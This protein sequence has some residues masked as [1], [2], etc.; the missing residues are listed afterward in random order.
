VGWLQN[1][2]AAMTGGG[3]GIGLAVVRR[4][5]EEGAAG[6]AVLDRDVSALDVLEREFPNRL[7]AIAGD[8]RDFASHRQMIAATGDRFGKL[9]VLVGNAGIFDFHRPLEGYAPDVLS[10]A[11][12]EIFA[13]NLKGYMLAALAAREA[14]VASRGSMIFTASVASFHA[15]GGGVLYTAVKHAVVGMIRELARELAPDVRVNG[16]GPGGTLT[17]LRGTVALGHAERSMADR[18]AET[19]ARIA[20][21]VPLR[22]AQRPNDHAGIYVLLASRENSPATTGEVIMSDGGIGIRPL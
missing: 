14:L 2:V 15:G 21:H 3:S 20:H 10:A 4:Y 19:E 6:I 5:L 18:A 16:V 8:V 17:N 13:V 22:F 11:F 7:I 12:D 9:D 1:Y